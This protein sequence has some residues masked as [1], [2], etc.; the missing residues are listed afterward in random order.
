MRPVSNICVA[1][2]EFDTHEKPLLGQMM[3]ARINDGQREIFDQIMASIE[4]ANPMQNHNYFSSTAQ[5]E[6]ARRSSKTP[7]S[8]CSKVKGNKSPQ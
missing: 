2:N 6:R 4:D 5:V 8:P 3:L 7:S 1:E